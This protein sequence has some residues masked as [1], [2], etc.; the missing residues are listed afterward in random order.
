MS[1]RAAFKAVNDGKQV[2]VLVPTT[3][4]AQQHFTTFRERFA[5]YPVTI[6]VISRFRSSGEQ[7]KIMDGIK[8]GTVDIIIGTHRL[9]SKDVRFKD[10]GL[11]IIDEEQ[12]F[13]VSHKENLNGS[14]PR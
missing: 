11:L 12:R 8:D 7:K 4:L 14:K 10:L 1:I 13:G 6:E 3:V 2:A 5:N 9:L